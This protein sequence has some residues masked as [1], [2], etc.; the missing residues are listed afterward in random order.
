LEE[1]WVEMGEWFEALGLLLAQRAGGR[2]LST[3]IIKRGVRTSIMAFL[4]LFSNAT[5]SHGNP[6]G[7]TDDPC[8]KGSL[9][10]DISAMKFAWVKAKKFGFDLFALVKLTS[11]YAEILFL[12]YCS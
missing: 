11:K 1:Q 3:E 6:H 7:F 9:E 4:W 5:L 8:T 10:P 2:V 12:N